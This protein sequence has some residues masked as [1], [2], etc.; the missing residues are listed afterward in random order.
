MNGQAKH[1]RS[2]AA[3][4][5]TD[6]LIAIDIEVQCGVIHRQH[7]LGIALKQVHL[8]IVAAAQLSKDAVLIAVVM[9]V[10]VETEEGC[11]VVVFP[12][13]GKDETTA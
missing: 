8:A 10:T 7:Q 6:H 12:I 4:Q 3:V 11:V 2:Q 5:Y 1:A 13:L 9:D